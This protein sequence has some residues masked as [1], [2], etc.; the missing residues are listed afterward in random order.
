MAKVFEHTETASAQTQLG[1]CSYFTH[2]SVRLLGYSL[3]LT[4]LEY[5]NSSRLYS[6][7][8]YPNASLVKSIRCIGICYNQ[9]HR[10]DEVNSQAWLVT[11]DIAH[12]MPR[13]GCLLGDAYG[14]SPA[15]CFI[16]LTHAVRFSELRKGG[17]DLELFCAS[18]NSVFSVSCKSCVSRTWYFA[19]AR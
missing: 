5:L 11:P 16:Q 18:H 12:V 13:N 1:G 19:H 15:C 4:L 17:A 10:K 9:A 6:M 2:Y 3:G 8:G 7:L 14:D